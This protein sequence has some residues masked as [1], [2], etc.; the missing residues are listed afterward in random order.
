MSK[1]PLRTYFDMSMQN[2]GKYWMIKVVAQTLNIWHRCL[3]QMAA[4]FFRCSLQSLQRACVLH[5]LLRFHLQ[6][7]ILLPALSR[8]PASQA[9]YLRGPYSW[10]TASSGHCPINSRMEPIKYA[11]ILHVHRVN[12]L[13]KKIGHVFLADQYFCLTGMISPGNVLR[14]S[15]FFPFGIGRRNLSSFN[16]QTAWW[17]GK[18]SPI[19]RSEDWSLYQLQLFKKTLPRAAQQHGGWPAN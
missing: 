8:C 12:I 3:W 13:S 10:V 7:W 16:Q 9:T 17:C 18:R 1:F 4:G 5:I 11:S 19:C 2:L 6:P 14:F 15:I